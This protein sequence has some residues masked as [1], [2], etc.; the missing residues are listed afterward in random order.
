MRLWSPLILRN[1]VS[2]EWPCSRER[3]RPWKHQRAQAR[4]DTMLALNELSLPGAYN[5]YLRA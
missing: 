1:K 5:A 3:D 4:Q 2:E